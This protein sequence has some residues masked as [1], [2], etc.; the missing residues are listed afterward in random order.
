MKITTKSILTT[1]IIGGVI[2]FFTGCRNTNETPPFPV[3]ENEYGQPG[4]KNLTFPQPDTLHWVTENMPG[5]RSLPTTKFDWDKLPS[6]PFDIGEP[7]A[8]T[9]PLTT[10]PFDWNALESQAFYLDSLPHT[11]LNVK[12]SVL[13]NP[14]IVKAGNPIN[15]PGATRGVSYLDANFGLPTTSYSKLIDSDGMIWFGLG[16]GVAKYD[17]ENLEIYANEQGVEGKFINWLHEDSKGRIWMVGNQ[18]SISVMD[19][20]SKLV[21]E[22]T[23]SYPLVQRYTVK[24]DANGL[25]WI[26]N[27]GTGVDIINLEEKIFWKFETKN[28]LLNESIIDLLMDS[29]GLVWICTGKGINIIDTANHTN[30]KLPN[31]G[32]LGTKNLISAFEDR[33]NN[34]WLIGV[35]GIEILNPSKTA[36]SLF[37]KENVKNA[38]GIV[39]SVFEDR[40]GNFWIGS[41]N[42]IVYKYSKNKRLITKFIVQPTEA[43]DKWMYNIQEDDQGQIWVVCAQGGIYKLD[44]NG[45]RPG[46][47]NSTHGLSSDFVTATIESDDGKI[48]IGTNTGID[49][50]NPE[51][52]TLKHLGV[53]EGLLDGFI[54]TLFRDSKNRIWVGTRTG[55][56]IIDPETGTIKNQKLTTEQRF[57]SIFSIAEKPSEEFWFVF[58]S[59]EILNLNKDQSAYKTLVGKDSLLNSS[60]K[61]WIAQSNNNYLLIG[62]SKYGIY[63]IDPDK[64][65]RWRLSE[66]SGL[67]SNITYA[68]EFDDQNNLWVATDRGVQM[69]D[70]SNHKITTF[71]IRE[72]L[73]ASD[74]YD[75]IFNDNKVFLATSK[76][77]T[78]LEQKNDENAH[79]NVKTIGKNQGLDYLDFFWHSLT[80]DKNGRLWAGVENHILT[81]M[82]AP[83]NDTNTYPAVITSLNIFD[84]KLIFSDKKQTQEKYSA[85]DTIWEYRKN[86]FSIKDPTIIDSSYQTAHKITW[87][88]LDELYNLPIGLTLPSDQNYLS[89]NYNGRQFS[90]QDKLVYRYILEGIDKQWSAINNKTTSENYRD[91]PPGNYTFKVASKG[92]NGVWSQPVEFSFSITPPWWQTWWAYLGY[93]MVL[94]LLAKQIHNYQK[95]KTVRI[96][97]EKSRE[98]ELAQA[99]EIEKAYTELKATQSQLIQSEKMASLGELTAG[100][101]HEI[102][103]PLNFVNNF[104]EINSELI[105]EM[106]E[107]LD[108][109]NLEEVQSLANH[110]NENEKK[111]MFH[112]KRA[113]S[114]VKGML[115]HSR[116]SNG[117]KELTNINA[118]ADEYLRLAYHGL[119][120]KDKSFNATMV[121]DFDESV[122]NVEIIPQ[123]IGRVILNLITNA[124]YVVDEK[125]K[126]DV[127]N[128]APTVT[129]STKNRDKNVEIKVT[130]N[131]NGIPES[132]LSK[133]F[134][135]FFT[136]KPTG[137][138]TGLGLSMSYDIINQSHGG[139]LTVETK[140]GLGTTFT[141][142]L[143]KN[144]K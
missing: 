48:W 116:I 71:T 15:L 83:N 105:E 138:G 55:F 67:I 6:K 40:S 9:K 134:E 92:F 102:Q 80:F 132:I 99:K 46:N 91:L 14:K 45:Y 8:I 16:N 84:K 128:Y 69:I 123:D 57:R 5:L 95:A 130:D 89:F 85:Q 101:A 108:K 26:A 76:G 60:R 118:L 90:N 110:I 129:V 100:I 139:N 133:I 106:K 140:Q 44:V 19:K 112:G 93:L 120:A 33:D 51:N 79:W 126:S 72:G 81:V 39:N 119:R 103:N 113:D 137:K 104:S 136:T 77:L 141:I 50:Y 62:D 135:P 94:G 117:K 3:L 96:E 82:D 63:K 88:G 20:K 29:K 41:D 61:Q 53:E 43:T 7:F 73:P 36:T 122:G 23:S 78:I 75:I 124:F 68:L 1:L 52:K 34:I 70:E 35:G 59:G 28:G 107:E 11:K 24:E 131:G 125:K 30:T 10:N 115:Q 56:S 121:T 74:V 58:G 64:K 32:S 21:Y 97:R 144:K 98:K 127:A 37:S 109:G 143:P 25:M 42:G 114:I 66:E 65:L 87:D 12:V 111:I 13:G 142:T 27:N 86:N 22:L 31:E 18:G 4:V 38:N 2:L 49:I 54:S 47:Y 17:S